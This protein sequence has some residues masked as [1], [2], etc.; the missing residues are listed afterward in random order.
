MP[1]TKTEDKTSLAF[2][3]G[4]KID[5][6]F[7]EAERKRVQQLVD[8]GV[9][10]MAAAEKVLDERVGVNARVVRER[11]GN[12]YPSLDSFLADDVRR[13]RAKAKIEQ[14]FGDVGP[15]TPDLARERAALKAAQEEVEALRKQVEDKNAVL[16]TATAGLS[17]LEALRRR[18]AEAEAEAERL[19]GLQ[20]GRTTATEV[21]S[22]DPGP[23]EQTGGLAGSTKR[24]DNVGKDER[25]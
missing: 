12:P 8:S 10:Q 16:T 11:D 9:D 5:P 22:V 17:E 19:R 2:E 18:V 15:V 24:T 7:S 13:L 3:A 14:E 23:G 21:Q 20:G 4:S 6:A 25:P 1:D